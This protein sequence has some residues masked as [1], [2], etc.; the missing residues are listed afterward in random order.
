MVEFAA[1]TAFATALFICIGLDISILIALVFGFFLF[2]FYGLFKKHSVREMLS[3]SLSGIN[4][5]K[6]V[7]IN[8]VLIGI[9][10][11][12]WRACG[13]IPFIVY[14]STAFCSPHLMVLTCFLLCSL[15]SFLTGTAFGTCATM[16]II[17][18]TVANSMGIPLII[19]GGAI[20]SG[21]YFGDRCSPMS[22][23]ALLISTLTKTDIFKNIKNMFKTSAVPF[24]LTC[25]IYAVA[26]LGFGSDYDISAIRS[27]FAENFVLHPAALI[28]AAVIILFSLFKVN[29]KITM[30]ISI[31]CAVAIAVF[32]QGIAPTALF[33][34]IISGY[35]PES[36]ELSALL[37]GGG[38]LS[39][40]RVFL[41][42]C[43]SSCYSGMF[44]G[45]GLL[46]RL[47]EL[48]AAL[49]KKITPFGGMFVSAVLTG[50]I[51]CN[52]TLTIMLTH[53]LCENTEDDPEQAAINLENTAVP[54]P[55]LIPWSTAAAV[56][57]ESVGAS[58]A[59][60]LTACYIYL[61][62]LCNYA[63][64]IYKSKKQ[65]KGVKK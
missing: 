12:V 44:S 10:T 42:V 41:I 7:L 53:Q 28:P 13:T 5:V 18:V 58:M 60:L 29:V 24:A 3:M 43:I 50:F 52:Q 38:I 61:L 26:G 49:S 55:A 20:I 64:A 37:S 30:G 23:S 14:H 9:I 21:A 8:F 6:N 34:T 16:G 65:N 11:A 57:V 1:L 32:I 51:A 19:S 62:P 47:K 59:C 2:F 35:R 27:L 39:M 46:D 54:L 22:T 48:T 40:V 63:H 25:I 17:C 4:S 31:A 15:I 36:N 33:E 45:T 56:P